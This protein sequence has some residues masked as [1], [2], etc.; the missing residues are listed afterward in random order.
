MTRADEALRYPVAGLLADH[1]GV[2]RTEAI[3]PVTI[4]AGPD[5]PL[6]TP[7]TGT[8][9]LVRTNRGLLVRVD[10]STTIATQCSRCLRD[11]DWPLE[12]HIDE[13]ALPSID[14]TTGHPLDATEEPE[15]VRLTDHHELDL[16]PLL[17]EAIQLG[18]PIAPLCRPDCPGLCPTCGR[19]LAEGSHDHPDEAIDPRLEG[20][21]A[22]RVDD[23][24]ESD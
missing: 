10:A 1:V 8:L 24:A 17:R 21:R 5:L 20:L 16:E 15:V 6:A 9:R 13:E 22:F 3:G 12:L 4:D 19:S 18:E 2:E 23:D 14:L 11:I 7:V